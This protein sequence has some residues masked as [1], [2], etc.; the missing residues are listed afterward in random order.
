MKPFIGLS[1]LTLAMLFVFVVLIP[2]ASAQWWGKKAPNT[3][4][5]MDEIETITRDM[6]VH[7]HSFSYTNRGITY[8]KTCEQRMILSFPSR[9][10]GDVEAA[11]TSICRTRLRSDGTV[12]ET[13]RV[14]A[15][16]A[17]FNLGDLD[18]NR[19]RLT[20]GDGSDLK[21]HL[22]VELH[23]IPRNGCISWRD[24]GGKERYF[25]IA[26]DSVEDMQRLKSLLVDLIN[27]L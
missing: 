16:Y 8:D 15:S 5:L 7:T 3:S 6:P 14:P 11:R 19:V 1:K 21:D 20:Q 13:I 27:L 25:S 23:C 12:I 24:S 17:V 4:D 22:R 2:T 10:T 18:A 26:S 9:V